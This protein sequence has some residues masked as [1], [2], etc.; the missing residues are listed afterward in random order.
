MDSSSC[1]EK[2]KNVKR[3]CGL[4]CVIRT[5]HTEMNN[6]RRFFGC[7]RYKFDGGCGFFLWVD[8]PR[9]MKQFEEEEAR[10]E[11]STLEAR[12]RTVEIQLAKVEENV[13]DMKFLC[14]I[15]IVICV[16]IILCVFA[17]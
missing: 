13:K 1:I 8:T 14:I 15:V 5:A 9:W 17:K 4:E 7:R 11:N 16:G 12:L 3:F 2:N 6:G 10:A